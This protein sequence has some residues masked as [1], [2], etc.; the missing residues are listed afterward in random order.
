[1]MLISSSLDGKSIIVP[2]FCI[3]VYMYAFVANHI[4]CIVMY[5]VTV[6]NYSVFFNGDFTCRK[7]D[8]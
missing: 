1:M 6:Y 4:V 5:S 8:N 3:Y 2:S 7:F